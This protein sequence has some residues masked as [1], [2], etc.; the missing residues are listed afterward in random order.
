M[1]MLR[2]LHELSVCTMLL[3]A[4]NETYF[5]KVRLEISTIILLSFY[6]KKNSLQFQLDFVSNLWLF[7]N[8]ITNFYG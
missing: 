4:N 7:A 1:R 5:R 3:S 8:L 2:G 6:N